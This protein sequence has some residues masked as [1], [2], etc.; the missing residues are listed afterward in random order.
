MEGRFGELESV[1]TIIQQPAA[2]QPSVREQEEGSRY[3]VKL[4]LGTKHRKDSLH[5]VGEDRAERTG[6]SVQP[7]VEEKQKDQI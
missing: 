6:C 2:S 7:E 1:E 4:K 5:T 3:Q